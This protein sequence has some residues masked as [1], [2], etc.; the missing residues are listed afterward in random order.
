MYTTKAIKSVNS[1]FLKIT[2]KDSFPSED[3]IKK[4]LYLRITEFYKK[5][6]GRAVAK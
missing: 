5:W 4:A 6:N 2:K 1:N 3:A